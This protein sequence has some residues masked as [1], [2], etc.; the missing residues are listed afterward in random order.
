MIR[1]RKMWFGLGISILLLGLFLTTAGFGLMLDALGDANYFYVIPAVGLYLASV[2]FRTI[3]WQMLMR[4]MRPVGVKRLYPVVVVGYMAN[5]LLPLRLGELVRS[6]Y[7]SEREG[8]SKTSALATIFVERVLDAIVLLLFIAVIAL[9]VPLSGLAEAFEDWSGVPAP[10]LVVGFSA[11]FVLAM[12]VLVLFATYPDRTNEGAVLMTRPLPERLR[13]PLRGLVDLFLE[14]LLPLRSPKT[15]VLL[16]AVSAPVWLFEAGLFL[17]IGFSFGLDRVY[18]N[19]GTMAAAMVLVTAIANIGS[20]V[21]AAPGGVGLFELVSRETLVLLPIGD[22]S[23]P[24]AAAFTTVAH[25]ALLLPMIILGQVFLWTE[26]LSLR[27][28]SRAGET[29]LDESGRRTEVTYP[30]DLTTATASSDRNEIE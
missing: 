21:P 10:L 25:A 15:L 27:T 2:L 3:R 14:G 23:R 5:N 20:S 18:D 16:L 28:L 22:I 13:T 29:Q 8:I 24:L 4:H 26:H 6:Y 19:F 30:P 1:S 11:P 12:A 9:F 17:L 7:L